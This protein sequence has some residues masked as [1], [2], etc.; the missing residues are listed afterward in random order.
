MTRARLWLALALVLC[1]A[2]TKADTIAVRSGEHPGFSRLVVYFSPDTDWSA[3][4]E[5]DRVV[6]SYASEDPLFFD[7]SPVFERIPRTRLLGIEERPA[8]RQ[9]VFRLGCPCGLAVT[10]HDRGY[11]ILDLKDPVWSGPARTP[12]APV[13]PPSDA[14]AL[15]PDVDAAVLA[16]LASELARAG[17][18]G[19][20]D[21]PGVP[22]PSAIAPDS[23]P[24][25][26]DPGPQSDT[27]FANPPPNQVRTI[28]QIDLDH[29]A[30]GPDPKVCPVE[31][32]AYD[33]EGWGLA[34]DPFQALSA[35]RRGMLDPAFV[36][37]AGRALQLARAYLWLG[38]GAE[39]QAIA[40][41]A[42]LAQAFPAQAQAISV[43]AAVLDGVGSFPAVVPPDPAMDLSS[44]GDTVILWAVLA[45]GP[46]AGLTDGQADA[47]VQG[48]GRL[49][50]HLRRHLGPMLHAILDAGGRAEAA[51]AVGQA[52]ERASPVPTAEEEFV[53]ALEDLRSGNWTAAEARLLRL[54]T[55]TQGVE[56]AAIA[57]LVA[58]Y[59]ARDMPPP[60]VILDVLRGL[61]EHGADPTADLRLIQ[62]L[63]L[64]DLLPEA[65]DRYDR[66]E[67]RLETHA[68]AVLTALLQ[69]AAD[70]GSDADFAR[71]AFAYRAHWQADTAPVDLVQAMDRRLAKLG[72]SVGA[73]G[74]PSPTDVPVAP[75]AVSGAGAAPTPKAEPTNPILAQL[76][77]LQAAHPQNTHS[78]RQAVRDA[79]QTAQLA[80][81][82][83]E[84]LRQLLTPT[85]QNPV[86]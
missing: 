27:V 5:G 22:E 63:I 16:G 55:G 65:F 74:R 17:S 72:L 68:P 81:D 23:D 29:A 18:Q 53:I 51:H 2:G 11:A 12:D 34:E 32:A 20:I 30:Q 21:V 26:P 59:R 37:D 41:L 38:F 80:A 14:T 82:R 28:T 52:I 46:G 15:V 84:L 49:P 44:C 57:S 50:V 39:A 33:V 58:E 43:I 24:P 54:A 35:G 31:A 3:A 36:V 13:A 7:V 42:D 40:Q 6:L 8:Q 62:M 69:A 86:N 61:S 67:D 1:G 79:A 71:A 60:P 77:A 78:G 4:L 10:R 73:T 47:A 66:S 83:L 48:F 76:D 56:L 64:A 70:R 25:G 9:V 19:L 85:A 75:D 45:D